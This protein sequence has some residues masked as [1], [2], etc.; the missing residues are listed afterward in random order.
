MKRIILIL[1]VLL[2]LA[3][4]GFAMTNEEFDKKIRTATTALDRLVWT[5]NKFAASQNNRYGD[6]NACL[7]A[8]EVGKKNGYTENNLKGIFLN[9]GIIYEFTK[10]NYI[11]AY[12]YYRISAKHG[13]PN[14]QICLDNLCRDH[15]WACK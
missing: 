8:I 11:R 14:A 10:K 1:G 4:N 2:M 13:E 15:S 9:T 12:E 3:Q 7:T 5:C 6:I